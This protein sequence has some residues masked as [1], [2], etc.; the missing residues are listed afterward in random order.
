[1]LSMATVCLLA[2]DICLPFW[3][4][5]LRWCCQAMGKH[6]CPQAGAGLT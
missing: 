4:C 1:M 3:P 2:D 6:S 5:Y